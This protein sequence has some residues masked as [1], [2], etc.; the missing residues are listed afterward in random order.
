MPFPVPSPRSAGRGLGR[1]AAAEREEDGVEH[2]DWLAEDEIGGKTEHRDATAS[3]E[4]RSTKIVVLARRF[5][6]LAAVE[7][8]G[9][10]PAGTV[11]VQDVRAAGMLAAELEAKESLGAQPSPQRILGVCAGT[12]QSTTASERDIHTAVFGAISSPLL[13]QGIDKWAGS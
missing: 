7:L 4:S 6:V 11:E 5:E 13:T 8:H 3:E 10:V 2:G 1:G 12:A 9:Q